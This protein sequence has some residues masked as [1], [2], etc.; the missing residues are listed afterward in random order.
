VRIVRPIARYRTWHGYDSCRTV[1]EEG[2]KRGRWAGLRVGR[3]GGE[4]KWAKGFE[5]ASFF[6]SLFFLTSNCVRATHVL[7]NAHYFSLFKNYTK[8]HIQM[9]TK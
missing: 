8:Y 3:F 2:K 9:S 5:R 7:T 4:R 1:D 6:F